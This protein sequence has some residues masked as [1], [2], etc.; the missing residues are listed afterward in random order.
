MHQDNLRQIQQDQYAI[1]RALHAY[2]D[3]VAEWARASVELDNA[4]DRME[5]AAKVLRTFMKNK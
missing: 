4:H 5:Q 1:N 3:A 2:Q